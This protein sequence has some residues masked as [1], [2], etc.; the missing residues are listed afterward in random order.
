MHVRSLTSL[1]MT[2][3]QNDLA[4]Q[5]SRP[6]WFS[7]RCHFALNHPKPSYSFAHVIP[8]RADGEGSPN[9]SNSHKLE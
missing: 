8:S 9:R 5:L 3:A 2:G 4:S 1:V 6:T 7:L